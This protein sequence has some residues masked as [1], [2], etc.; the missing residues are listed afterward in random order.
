M[1]RPARPQIR[2]RSQKLGCG[3]GRHGADGG[4]AASSSGPHSDCAGKVTEIE[5]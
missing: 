4:F 2:Q 5:A 3:S 1:K